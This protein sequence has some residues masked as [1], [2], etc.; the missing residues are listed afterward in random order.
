VS[1]HPRSAPRSERAGEPRNRVNP[2]GLRSH[3]KDIWAGDFL[4][5]TDLLFRP[6]FAF[7]IIERATRRVVHVAATRHPTDA[8]AAQQQ[9][10]ATPFGRHP[11]Y[12]IRDHDGKYGAAF[13]AVAAASGIASVRRECLDHLRIFGERHLARVLREYA[14]YDNRARPHQGLGQALLE[15]EAEEVG[16]RSGPIRALPVLGGLHHT[17]HRAA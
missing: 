5:V 16:S 10:E 14:A 1:T 3:A 2:T 4:P 13:A 9:C 6:L 11:R 17:Y 8:W 7:F 15:P 12:L